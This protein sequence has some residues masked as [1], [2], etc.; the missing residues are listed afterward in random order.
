MCVVGA[1]R[2]A[3]AERLP[4]PEDKEKLD[5]VEGR[6]DE[7]LDLSSLRCFGEALPANQDAW[8]TSFRDAGGSRAGGRLRQLRGRF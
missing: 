2:W 3:L 1:R 8:L 6:L 7:Q 5:I 4:S